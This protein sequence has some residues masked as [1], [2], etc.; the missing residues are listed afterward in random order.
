MIHE[1]CRGADILVWDASISDA[2]V[3]S[4]ALKV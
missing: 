2:R 1:T 3:D 4:V